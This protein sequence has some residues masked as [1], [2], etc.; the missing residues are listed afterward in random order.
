MGDPRFPFRSFWM[1][2]YEG[3]DHV[4]AHGLPLDMA[5]CNDHTR[6]LNEDY[7]SAAALGAHAGRESIGWRLAEREA[8]R[9]DLSRVR[10]I[11]RCASQHGLQ[12]IWTFMHYGV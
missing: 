11:A 8:G 4:N 12:V 6:R 7:A 2:G 3:A 10:R 9:W 5:G 1:G